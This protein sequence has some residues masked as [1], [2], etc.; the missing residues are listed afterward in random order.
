LNLYL[1]EETASL[2]PK[3]PYDHHFIF[4]GAAKKLGGTGMSSTPASNDLLRLL[5]IEREARK[6][7]D[8]AHTP[9][10]D[11]QVDRHASSSVQQTASKLDS[12]LAKEP[13][14]RNVTVTDITADDDD[15][16]IVSSPHS[17]HT[18]SKLPIPNSGAA[19]PTP[20]VAGAQTDAQQ[21]LDLQLALTMQHEDDWADDFAEWSLPAP[22]SVGP[23]SAMP[24]PTDENVAPDT[25][26]VP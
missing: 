6:S 12:N 3:S 10:P 24:A 23:D 4:S 13:L 26:E 20:A 9:T 25:H 18:S 7:K 16:I 8:N 17:R 14:K 22:S 19:S 1:L 5:R 2:N 11:E 21:D 15:I